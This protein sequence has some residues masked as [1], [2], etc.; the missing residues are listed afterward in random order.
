MSTPTPGNVWTLSLDFYNE[1]SGTLTDPSAV[2]L[3]I[4]YGGQVGLV[5]D[6]AGPFTYLGSAG[7]SSTVVYRTATGQFSFD[8][9]IPGNAAPGVYV[10]NWTVTFNGDAFLII[11]NFYVTGGGPGPLVVGGDLGFWTGSLAY[12]PAYLQSPLGISFGTGPDT[13]GISWLWQKID[14]WDSPPVSGQVT[15]RADDQGGWPTAQYYAPRTMTVTVTASA[16]TQALRDLARAQLQQIIPV[17]DLALM[18]YNEPQAKQ[19]YV[20]RSGQIVETPPTLA[21]VT[22]AC[23][24]VAPDPRKYS[25]QQKTA[26]GYFQSSNYGITVPFT[27]PFTLPAQPLAGSVQCTNNGTFETRPVITINGPVSSPA[28]TNTATGQTVSWNGLVL[29]AG[30]QLVVDMDAKQPLLNG[31]LRQA[32]FTSAWWV[33]NPGSSTIQLSGVTPGGASVNVAWRDA[34]I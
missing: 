23:V 6:Y 31:A 28:I 19:A 8:W 29:N 13:N 5:P 32:D 30:D 24:I 22:F 33:L 11:E 12:Q 9:N 15:Q 14:G 17:N 4:T 20:R 10:A 7:P 1:Q 25:T 34:W 2:Q 26:T 27:V 3:D 21:D 16:P 18:T